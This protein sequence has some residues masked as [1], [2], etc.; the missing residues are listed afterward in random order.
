MVVCDLHILKSRTCNWM[1]VTYRVSVRREITLNLSDNITKW[2][3]W[4]PAYVL[5]IQKLQIIVDPDASC[6]VI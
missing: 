3:N 2:R 5:H 4:Q 1:E 6:H